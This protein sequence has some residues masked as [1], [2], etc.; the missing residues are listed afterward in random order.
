MGAIAFMCVWWMIGRNGV[1]IRRPRP[2]FSDYVLVIVSMFVIAHLGLFARTV[3]PEI[4]RSLGG[5]RPI[6]ATIVPNGVHTLENLPSLAGVDSC[7]TFNCK[8]LLET[9][10][11]VVLLPYDSANTAISIN[12]DLI[13]ALVLNP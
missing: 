1:F 2:G 8:L 12:K 4:P 3:Y 6:Q 13:A 11:Q 7:G 10:D 5:G 9:S